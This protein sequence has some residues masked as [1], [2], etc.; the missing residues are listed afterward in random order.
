MDKYILDT[1]GISK[2]LELAKSGRNRKVARLY[3]V[4]GMATKEIADLMGY[5]ESVII[6]EIMV[7]NRIIE[8]NISHKTCV[9]CGNTFYTDSQKVRICPDCKE[10]NRLSQVKKVQEIY[11]SATRPTTAKKK[12]KAF[13]SLA[14]IEKERAV[15]NKEH[16]PYLEYG[17]FVRLMG[18]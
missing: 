17:E 7:I 11:K 8:N 14:Q 1:S 12:R 2:M 15:Y 5:A 16:K 10:E 9:E 18:Y 4:N 6:S 13:K 3:Y